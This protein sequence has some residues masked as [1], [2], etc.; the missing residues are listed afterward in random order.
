MVLERERSV[1]HRHRVAHDA[2]E[3]DEEK[4][5]TLTAA[6]A[7]RA[8]KV[9]GNPVRA[10]SSHRY[11][12]AH[13]GGYGEGDRFVG[14]T[15]PQLHALAKQ[16]LDLPLSQID[17][18][19][20]NEIHEARS[21]ALEIMVWR[22]SRSDE[23]AQRLIF[24]LYIRRLR[25]INNWDL[26]DGSAPT[27]IGGYLEVHPDN[28]L[29]R[30]LVSSE[31]VWHRRIAVLGTF[32]QIR[33]GKFKPTLQLCKTLLGDPHDLMHKACGWMLREIGKRDE[34]T[35]TT[36]LDRYAARMPRT[37]LRYSIERL[38]IQQRKCYLACRD[39]SDS[40]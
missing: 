25:Y 23:P 4:L 14:L 22:Y 28:A 17:R 10:A 19:L 30:K 5:M 21:L 7:L 18:L 29:I 20:C 6:G 27:I 13:V 33:T 11:L 31:V 37:M 38:S 16:F 32:H 24:S 34:K 3:A 1:S 2:H 35:L 36:W 8:L 9:A 40:A 39:E 12:Q 26:I 15:A